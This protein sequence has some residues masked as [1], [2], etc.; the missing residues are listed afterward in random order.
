MFV[1]TP[2]Q[3]DTGKIDQEREQCRNNCKKKKRLLNFH[4]NL[5]FL[6]RR[7]NLDRG[8]CKND[9]ELD[10]RQ[11]DGKSQEVEKD[12]NVGKEV[13]SEQ[14][15]ARLFHVSKYC[16]WINTKMFHLPFQ[17]EM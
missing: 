2:V 4:V 7:K 13:A 3:E 6:L 9:G 17:E 1:A 8:C 10:S 11:G 5:Q 12:V 14:L 16:L 15:P